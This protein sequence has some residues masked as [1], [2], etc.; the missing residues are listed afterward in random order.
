MLIVASKVLT[1]SPAHT[2]RELRF[3]QHPGTRRSAF[4]Q[5]RLL[6]FSVQIIDVVLAGPRR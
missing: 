2:L 5:A 3:M 6:T 1:C 4:E